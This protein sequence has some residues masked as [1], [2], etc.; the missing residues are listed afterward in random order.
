MDFFKY[1][2][3]VENISKSVEWADGQ[4]VFSEECESLDSLLIDLSLSIYDFSEEEYKNLKREIIKK[5]SESQTSENLKVLKL[6]LGYLEFYRNCPIDSESFS[7]EERFEKSDYKTS[8]KPHKDWTDEQKDCFNRFLLRKELNFA[9]KKICKESDCEGMIL[10]GYDAREFSTIY[11]TDFWSYKR[12]VFGVSSI[13]EYR[14]YDRGQYLNYNNRDERFYNMMIENCDRNLQL[15]N[16]LRKGFMAISKK[17]ELNGFF[18][19]YCK[20]EIEDFVQKNIEIINKKI[21]EIENSKIEIENE[22]K[23]NVV[24]T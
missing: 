16:S 18:F 7:F 8:F 10:N 2:E 19:K 11:L 15:Y 21:L 3:R 6:A 17:D 22:Y 13:L 14:K 24:Q 1:I 12:K 23:A 20:E 5:I 9:Y 4:S